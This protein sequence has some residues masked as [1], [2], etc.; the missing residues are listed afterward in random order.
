MQKPV[1]KLFKPSFTYITP[2]PCWWD[3]CHL[4]QRW[5]VTDAICICGNKKLYK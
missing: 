2:W 3:V 5:V 1:L 4:V